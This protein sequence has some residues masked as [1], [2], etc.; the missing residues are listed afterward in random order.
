MPRRESVQPNGKESAGTGAQTFERLRQLALDLF[1]EKGYRKTSTRDLA[2]ALGVQQ[3]S[4][5]YYFNKKEELLYDICYIS[6]EQIVQSAELAAAESADPLQA[7]GAI[8]RMHLI[9]TLER[10][11]QMLVS[12][13]DYRSLSA[14]YLERINSFW[15]RYEQMVTSRYERAI[16]AG[17]MRSDIP[18]KY[19]YH[20]VMSMTNWAVLWY[21]ADGELPLDELG[22]IFSD[23]YVNGI[24]CSRTGIKI[25]QFCSAAA[26]TESQPICETRNETH[27]RL[28]D[29][30]SQLF[31]SGGYTTTSIREVAISMGIEKASLYYY[32]NSKDDL[33]HQII[34]SAH[35]HMLASLHAVLAGM[36]GAE[37][38]LLRF[39]VA[40]VCALLEHKNWIAV[41]TEQINFLEA[42][43]RAQIVALRDE[44]EQTVRALL[45]DAQAAGLVRADIPAR[46][47][48]FALLGM[49]THIYPWYQEEIDPPPQ[50]LAV[51]LAD[52]LLNGIRQRQG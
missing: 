42:H 30:A 27:A 10:Q 13:Y 5:Y 48:G 46:Y 21:R 41:A 43:K 26:D 16:A 35:E 29:T 12:M 47:L 49:I 36:E 52:I 22:R 4:L 38:R 24:S 37:S 6:L 15:T 45:A 25:R 11:R 8:A 19:H 34:L 44:Y 28:L 20:A 40:H 14:R 7:L 51:L 31:A 32:I 39:I 3:A 1:W 9:A 18:H 2:A 50:E 33:C 23:I 17:A